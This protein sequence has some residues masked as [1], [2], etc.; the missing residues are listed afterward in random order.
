MT[1]VPAIAAPAALCQPYPLNP[2]HRP[3]SPP[4]NNTLNLFGPPK[5]SGAE[6]CN[7]NTGAGRT[8]CGGTK[9]SLMSL[10]AGGWRV[11]TVSFVCSLLSVC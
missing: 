3:H 6:T 9:H 8:D 10:F 2:P 4:L 11:L 5:P 7:G 1:F